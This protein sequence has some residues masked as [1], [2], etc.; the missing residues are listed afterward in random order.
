[1]L[2]STSVRVWCLARGGGDEEV[3]KRIRDAMQLYK[4]WDDADQD[5]I[6]AVAG[7]LAAPRL[8]L[9][10]SGFGRLAEGIDAIYHVGARVNHIEPYARMRAANVEG[11]REVL[12]LATTVRIKPVHFVSTANTVVPSNAGPD[13]IGREDTR[14][15]VAEISPNGY[16][17]SKWASEQ[18]VER[19]GERGVPVSIYRPGLV[20]GDPRSGVNSVDDSFWNMIRAA[21]ILGQA[22]DTGD[23]A[24][25]MAPVNYVSAAI[26]ALAARPAI[27][28]AYHLVNQQPVLVREIFEAVR[29][30][31][32]PIEIVPVEQVASRLAE[33]A[34]ARDAAGDDSLVRAALVS[35]NYGGI[36]APID[37][38][39]TRAELD[40]MQIRCPEVDA[41]T[42]DAYIGAF[43][44]SGFF[45]A[46]G[47]E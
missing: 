47:G 16:V 10:E 45:P 17:A 1:L 43:V 22:P 4:I 32:I 15:S 37:D 26:V 20:C 42:L 14:L 36:S 13:F 44:E 33:Q 41:A 40:A 46:P 34:A 3:Y 23:A 8:G 35:G 5:R 39:R 28:T 24:M 2:D 25:P 38:T 18:L 7:D 21:A 6:V 19:A 29:R 27:G 11:T 9:D 30:H 12:R 31:G